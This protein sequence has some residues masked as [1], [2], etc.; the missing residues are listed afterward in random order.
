MRV[1]WFTNTPSKAGP[2]FGYKK[3]GGGWVLALETL[4]VS[5]K[6]HELGICFF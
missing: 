4:V 5:E 1:L 6:I 3:F 2:E